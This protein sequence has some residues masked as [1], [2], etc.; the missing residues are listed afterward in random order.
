MNYI[1]IIITGIIALIVATM[2]TSDD[3]NV[4]H[5]LNLRTSGIIVFILSAASI[6]VSIINEYNEN[7]EKADSKLAVHNKEIQDSLKY[8]Q[9]SLIFEK[10]FILDSLGH[11]KTLFDLQKQRD[12]DSIQL[13]RDSLHFLAT[14]D[15]FGLQLKSQQR[16]L[17][18]LNS[19]LNPLFPLRISCKVFIKCSEFDNWDS[20][21]FSKLKT[22]FENASKEFFH[23]ANAIGNLYF[24]PDRANNSYFFIGHYKH[25]ISYMTNSNSV[26]YFSDTTITASFDRFITAL[27]NIEL[28]CTFANSKTNRKLSFNLRPFDEVEYEYRKQ[29]DSLSITLYNEIRP[30]NLTDYSLSN[31]N[32]GDSLFVE[33]NDGI[34]TPIKIKTMSIFCGY[35]YYN[36]YT[37]DNMYQYLNK[38][39]AL[40]I[41]YALKIDDKTMKNLPNS[42]YKEQ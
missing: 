10:R 7:E 25:K 28:R 30:Y 33:L 2:K 6:V 14:L 29:S 32:T 12:L 24:G 22:Q 5:F 9:D 16:T 15:K 8:I 31:I 13:L 40:P 1:L 38:S 11:S 18:D 39:F 19:V 27:T 3:K 23:N 42:F 35:D 34:S 4:K 20:V 41:K 36:N 17:S 37:I 21:K 26:S